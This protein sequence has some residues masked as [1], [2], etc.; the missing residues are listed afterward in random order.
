MT[1]I[2]TQKSL[3][4]PMTGARLLI[5]ED[6]PNSR[7]VLCALLKR[8]GFD[9]RVANDG[10]EALEV[11]DQFRPDV[12]LMDLMMPGVNG[13]E[14]IRRLKADERTRHIPI[15]V[16]TGDL[17]ARNIEAAN[18]AGCDDLFAQT[19]RVARA[20]R[21]HQGPSGRQELRRS[22]FHLVVRTRLPMTK[23]GQV[24]FSLGGI[25]YRRKGASSRF[26]FDKGLFEGACGSVD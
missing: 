12:I 20:G 2:S 5:A 16:L 22:D 14:A 11:V 25:R 6:D 8:L 19:G 7:W 1:A 17:T 13:L 23:S 26:F 3:R 18:A 4:N 21:A 15:L 10:Q 24:R 9:C